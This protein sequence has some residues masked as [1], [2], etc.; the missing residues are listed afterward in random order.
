[1]TATK[2]GPRRRRANGEGSVYWEESRQR[3]AGA[4][5]V[6]VGTKR[7]RRLVR[8]TTQAEAI[9]LLRKAQ[10]GGPPAPKAAA[11]GSGGGMT[12]GE[13]LDRWV[14]KVLPQ[15][16]I[17]AVTQRNYTETVRAWIK[18]YVGD[19]PLADLGPE[20]VLAMMT[21]LEAK[22]LSPNS[23]RLARTTLRRAL[24]HAERFGHVG[25]NVAALT[26]A[27][28]G[29]E[30]KTDDTLSAAE[31]DRVLEA[32]KADRLGALAVLVLMV[33]VRQGEALRLRW[34]HL[35]LE[36]EHGMAHIPGTKSKTSVRD[37]PLP[38][39]VVEAL[40]QHRQSQRLERVAAK[41]WRDG[42]LVFATPI[43]T[44]YD[45]WRALRWW[46]LLLDAAGVDQRRFHASRHT[47]ATLMLNNGVPLEVISRILGHAS[48]AITSDIYAQPGAE[49]LRSGA[50]AMDRLFGGRG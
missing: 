20:D 41:Y 37:V 21:E 1:M 46:H 28:K 25:R 38:A 49:M 9:R 39:I 35:D 13:W 14:D 24:G 32:A 3:W 26:D 33:G 36:G 4:Y 23:R 40:R 8:A 48:L 50:D 31:A 43:G 30:P 2:P 47:A 6:Q 22:G 5:F 18:P 10:A 45:R 7:A 15:A 11:K 17:A 19:I 29:T 42:G 12:T 34:E 27:P 16:G 44:A